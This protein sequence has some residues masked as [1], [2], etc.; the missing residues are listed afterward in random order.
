MILLRFRVRVINPAHIFQIVKYQLTLRKREI[1]RGMKRR[2]VNLSEGV[3]GIDHG[4]GIRPYRN[5]D[6]PFKERRQIQT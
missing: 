6:R 1:F 3:L 4:E 2:P 5:I